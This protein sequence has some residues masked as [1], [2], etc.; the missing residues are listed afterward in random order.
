MSLTDAVCTPAEASFIRDELLGTEENLEDIAKKIYSSL[1][2]FPQDDALF[3]QELCLLGRMLVDK[4]TSPIGLDFTDQLETIIDNDIDDEDANAFCYNHVLSYGADKRAAMHER[5][6]GRLLAV[7]SY[8]RIATYGY[9]VI[10]PYD[11]IECAKN[12]ARFIANYAPSCKWTRK[13]DTYLHQVGRMLLPSDQVALLHVEGE[14]SN[15]LK[16]L[17]SYYSPSVL[18]DL[19]SPI[20]DTPPAMRCFDWENSTS[21]EDFIFATSLLQEMVDQDDL[22]LLTGPHM[23]FHEKMDKTHLFVVSNNF[24]V[25]ARGFGLIDSCCMTVVDTKIPYSITLTLLEIIIKRSNN[26]SYT[27]LLECCRNPEHVSATNPFSQLLE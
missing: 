19:L 1:N 11:N 23:T 15:P 26:N 6:V 18:T 8:N 22:F 3:R 13:N 10:Q 25:A 14:T 2:A 7:N 17:A 20:I 24:T 16:R 27:H 9:R 12:L 21:A 5:M 4:E